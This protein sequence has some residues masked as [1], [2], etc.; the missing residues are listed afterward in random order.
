MQ[1]TTP[2]SAPSPSLF[3]DTANAF[4][5]TAAL[6]AAVE[7]KLFTAIAQG[8]DTA[9]ALASH[10]K[11]APRGARILADY[12]TIAGFLTKSADR[13]A[14]TPD[15]A[16]FLNEHSRAY[17]GAAIEFLCSP[18]SFAGFAGLT[19]RVRNGGAPPDDV[20]LTQGG[21]H[22]WVSFARGMAGLMALPADLL[23]KL[24]L[25]GDASPM[26]I[27]DI[28]AS[29]GLFGLAFATHNP[30]AKVVALD[31]P[32]VLEVARENAA[33]LNVLSRFETLP[34]SVFDVDFGK[35][36][37]IILLPN[38]LHHFDAPS[39]ERLL[40]KVHAA[41]KPTGRAV[42]LEFIPN[43]DRI[44]PPTSAA[45]SLVMLTHTAHGDAYTLKE[46]QQMFH[47]AGFSQTT[48]HDLPPTVEQVLIS[49]K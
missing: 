18:E 2:Q 12:L 14:L 48:F 20:A 17:A 30:N 43:D 26:K 7:L 31:F 34:G 47:N 10:C 4:Q 37:D 36:F 44:S 29:H 45:F 11:I 5:R 1:P 3:F 16:L 28:A 21:Q 13:Y 6:K 19:D 46:F 40:K 49:Q 27:L 33:H 8:H 41:L 25:N 38:I 24:T 23:A 22:R 15:S 42:T 9:A 32:V 39:N 35:D